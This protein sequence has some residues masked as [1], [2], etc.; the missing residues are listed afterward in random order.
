[1]EFLTPTLHNFNLLK[2]VLFNGEPIILPTDTNYNLCCLPDS[3]DAIDKIFAFKKR[4]KNK[5][6]SLFFSDPNDW[7]MFGS[8][9]QKVLMDQLTTE[10]WPGPL[11]IIID[12]Q[13][14]FSYML[15]NSSTIALGCLQ[16][17]TFRD[18]SKF[19]GLPLAITSAN[20]S[21]TAD[22]LLITKEV[23]ALHMGTRVKYLLI[24]Q[25]ENTTSMSSTIVKLDTAGISLVRED[26]LKFDTILATL[27]RGNNQ[28]EK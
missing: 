18:F 15:N 24:S 13:T 21:G 3:T 7:K 11:N 20:I 17:K 19:L 16:N 2:K 10:F 27:E 5:P 25:E 22:D 9:P 1:M 14:N 4:P 23:A 26:D 8:T 12:N 28:F 6:L